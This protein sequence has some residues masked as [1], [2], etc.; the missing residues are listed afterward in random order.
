M[1][2]SGLVIIQNHTHTH[3]LL[4]T[5]TNEEIEREIALSSSLIESNLAHKPS[6]IAYPKGDYNDRVIACIKD[7][8]GYGFTVA[9]GYVRVGIDNPLKLPR[10]LISQEV[11][12][13][14]FK[15]MLTRYFWRLKRFKNFIQR[16]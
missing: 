8:L 7:K 11:S 5:Q 16:V 12:M 15:F 9:G 1:H 4:T 2:D 3:P 14:K 10:L 6:A 13:D